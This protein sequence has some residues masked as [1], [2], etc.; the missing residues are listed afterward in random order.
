LHLVAIVADV[1]GA[2]RLP[3]EQAP[4]PYFLRSGTL[5]HIRKY[6]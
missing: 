3:S 1:L 6:C 4:L 5:R 2:A